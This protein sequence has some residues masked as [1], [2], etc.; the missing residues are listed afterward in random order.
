MLGRIFYILM[1]FAL[2]CLAAG[3]TK[4]LFAT[5]P[6]ELAGLP[7]DV[8][9]DRMSKVF[10][11][12]I[13]AGVVT[14]MFSAPFAAV[15]AAIGEWRRLRDWTYY[16]LSGV[17]I[18]LVGFLAQYSGEPQGAP[19]IVNNYALTA[20]LTA[21]FVGGLIYWLFAGRTAGV[22]LVQQRVSGSGTGNPGADNKTKPAMNNNH[23]D[24]AKPKPATTA[25]AS[26]ASS[27][28]KA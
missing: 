7:P 17:A 11:S 12:G 16:A 3:L 14:G 2:A 10:E 6:S 26:S 13:F 5:T 27:P 19:S 1:S 4:V 21:G 23:N 28:K 20:F 22:E 18:A 15:V 25:T 24:K 8:A 9:A